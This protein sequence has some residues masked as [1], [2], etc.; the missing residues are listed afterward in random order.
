MGLEK[1]KKWHHGKVLNIKWGLA[2]NKWNT[3]GAVVFF[4]PNIITCVKN[5]KNKMLFG[6]YYLIL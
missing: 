4:L 6:Y 2:N 1:K 3:L 5:K